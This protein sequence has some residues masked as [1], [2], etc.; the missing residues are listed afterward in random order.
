VVLTLLLFALV[1]AG[2][3]SGSK[4]YVAPGYPLK[5][6]PKVALLPLEDLTGRGEVAAKMTHIFFVE[7]VRTGVCDVVEMGE[8]EN[9]VRK[10]RIRS[11]GSLS[12]DQIDAIAETM[13]VGFLM[14]GTVLEA[15][16]IRTDRGA[17]PALG[18]TLKLIEVATKKIIWADVV[19]RTGDDGE[20]IFGWGREHSSEQLA[21]DAARD[22]FKS[23]AELAPPP[24]KG[25]DGG[26]S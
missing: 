25:N 12:N 19:N 10:N 17:I 21:T 4:A 20:T 5:D 24:S 3:G 15:G 11:T 6:R 18:V 7:L 2:C 1:A 13:G 9:A 22:M 23:L 14:T 16:T 8:S 26:Q